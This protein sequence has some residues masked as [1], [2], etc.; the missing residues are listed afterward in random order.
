MA[1]SNKSFTCCWNPKSILEAIHLAV[2]DRSTP[3][4]FGLSSRL[5]F[6]EKYRRGRRETSSTRKETRCFLMEMTPPFLSCSPL[7]YMCRHVVACCSMPWET[8]ITW[9]SSRHLISYIYRLESFLVGIEL[10]CLFYQAPVRR[11]AVDQI[12]FH[13]W[14]SR[15]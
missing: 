11:V 3:A 6:F 13:R 2:D 8:A 5:F 7:L 15:Y 9:P 12:P 14:P 4:H 10:L 1:T